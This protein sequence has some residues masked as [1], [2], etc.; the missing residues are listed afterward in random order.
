MIRRPWVRVPPAP[1]CAPRTCGNVSA[2]R[3]FRTLGQRTESAAHEFNS[4]AAKGSSDSSDLHGCL[5][6]W[7]GKA[8]QVA[9]V[10]GW[11]PNSGRWQDA[12]N[13]KWPTRR[14]PARHRGGG[15]RGAAADQRVARPWGREASA[16]RG[17]GG[18]G[19]YRK[20]TE[21]TL[22]AGGDGLHGLAR[23]VSRGAVRVRGG[24]S[25][26]SGVPDT[27]PGSGLGVVGEV[28]CREA[29]RTLNA[30]TR[31]DG[32]ATRARP[33]RPHRPPGSTARSGRRG[34][35]P[36]GDLLDRVL[37]GHP[38]RAADRSAGQRDRPR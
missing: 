1:L 16:D 8:L 26:R 30:V 37:E 5:G 35:W 6:S 18:N 13:R 29:Q 12:G 19:P 17:A 25:G 21:G 31:S 27:L 32:L 2:V 36:P 11:A 22:G 23:R 20:R 28:P 38:P 3:G 10:S 15:W 4:V 14:H 33:A 24:G 7:P 34:R 9:S